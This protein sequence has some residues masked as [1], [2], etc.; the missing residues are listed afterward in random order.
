MSYEA[1][2]QLIDDYGDYLML[3]RR[4]S[5]ATLNVY[6]QEITLFLGYLR[7]LSL[8]VISVSLQDIETYLSLS[9]KDRELSARTL[10]RN[11]S[12]LR[13]FF[14]YLQISK[15]REDN[16][17]MQLENPKIGTRFPSVATLEEIDS[18]FSVID[19]SDPLGFRDR[20]LFELIY[21]CGLRISET[22][23]LKVSDYEGRS[24][25][26]LGKRNKM[27]LVPVGEIAQS[28]VDEYL[29][30]IRVDLVK[31]N[32]CEKALFVGRNGHP[33]T[34]QAVYKRFEQYCDKVGLVAK[35]HTLR[36]SFAT[37]LLEGGADLR[38][39][40]E[41]LGHSDIKTTQIYTH[42]HTDDLKRAYTAFHGNPEE[43]K[44]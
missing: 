41:L 40:Q 34:R 36:H 16:P 26:V 3:Q 42:V 9:K 10:A 22:C 29:L 31:E 18:L 28:F 25:R 27:R 12:S 14:I 37:H 20:A 38:S 1:D 30:K 13:S 32:L 19:V 6:T 8:D 17:V 39:V 24:L 43:G 44:K 33:L 21:S 11:L 7:S 35:V 4:L 5:K 23:D 15:I 2:L